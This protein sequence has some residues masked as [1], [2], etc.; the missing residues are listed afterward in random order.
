MNHIEIK[1][2]TGPIVLAMPHSGTYLPTEIYDKLNDNGKEL[3]DTDWHLME[4]YDGLQPNA[5]IVKA[6]F[7]RYVI[8]AN[9]CPDGVSLYPGANTTTLCP[10]IDFVNKPIWQEGLVPTESDIEPRIKLFHTPYHKA[11]HEALQTARSNHGYAII[12]DCHSIRSNIPFLF[13]GALPNLNIG[14]NDSKSC[15]SKIEQ[16]AENICKKSSFSTVTNGRFK[17]GWT[18]RHYGKPETD[19]HA[20]QM[21]ITQSSYMQEHAPWEYSNEKANILR[22]TLANILSEIEGIKL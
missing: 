11:L 2:G 9:R 17:G 15:D 3:A 10:L 4:L 13:D 19:I 6:N 22:Q 18:T 16:I 1:Q 5:A 21:E 7:H 20:I 8:D 14:T 12:Y